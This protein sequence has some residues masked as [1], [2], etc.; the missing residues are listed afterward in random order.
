[1]KNTS[2]N[3]NSS[4][5]QDAVY[6]LTETPLEEDN[7]LMPSRDILATQLKF[8]APLKILTTELR[9]LSTGYELDRGKLR[10]QLCQ[11]LKREVVALQR[12]CS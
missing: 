11:C 12:C 10:Y 3:N 9:T 7:I 4:V 1:M 5:F 6:P 8:S 2:T